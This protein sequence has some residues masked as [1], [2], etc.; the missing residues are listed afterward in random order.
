MKNILITRS[1]KT[2]AKL[3]QTLKGRGF[4][5]FCEAL[6]SVEKLTTGIVSTPVSAAII[7]SLN[8]C[9]A[10]EYSKIEKETKIFTVG[11]KTAEELR[12]LGFNNII[13]SPQNSAESLFDLV[14]KEKGKILYFR[15]SLIS[16]DFAK[17][18]KNIEEI[19]AYKTHEIEDFSAEFKKLLQEEIFDEVL[20][21]SKN[22]LEIFHK[23]ITKHNMLEYFT[24]SQMLCLSQQILKRAKELGFKKISTFQND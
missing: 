4:N 18:S 7:T 3:I 5:V 17:K 11:K 1:A 12:H 15:G 19:R 8:A 14:E 9:S 2:S 6:F 13:L 23:L 24:N 20:I 16:F 22:S 21:F 10:L